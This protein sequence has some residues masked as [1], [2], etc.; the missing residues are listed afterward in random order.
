M[1]HIGQGLRAQ[2]LDEQGLCSALVHQRHG[3]NMMQHLCTNRGM[4]LDNRGKSRWMVVKMMI[5][6][7]GTLNIRC[8]IMIR[9]QKGTIILNH[10]CT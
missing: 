1:T 9:S 2:A 3:C 5:P 4:T 8:R 6:F 10:P 7:L